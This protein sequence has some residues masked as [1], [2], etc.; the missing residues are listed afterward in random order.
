MAAYISSN[1][2]LHSGFTSVYP[3]EE[4]EYY[5]LSASQKR[6]YLLY[7]MTEN[8]TAYNIPLV[9]KISGKPNRKRL[10]KT[11]RKLIQRHECLRTTFLTANHEPVQ[12]I[13]GRVSFKTVVLNL[14]GNYGPEIDI[15]AVVR[16]FIRPFD[17]SKAPLFR[18][19]LINVNDVDSYHLLVI[20]IHHV[21]ADGLS[22]NVM[23]RDF[24]VLY[25]GGE[26]KRLHTRYVDYAE[27]QNLDKQKQSI[28]QQEKYWLEQYRNDIP[29]LEL[30]LDYPRPRNR[31]FSGGAVHFS[32]EKSVLQ[33]LED[34]S[35]QR[36]TTLFMLLLALYHIFLSK[37]TGQ[38]EIVIG[39]PVSGRRHA[40]LEHLMGVFINTLALRNSSEGKQTFSDFLEQIKSSSL[41]AF[42]NQDYP[43]EEL[44]DTVAV[45]R[46]LSRNPIFDTTFVLN[47]HTPGS[48][49]SDNSQEVR[50]EEGKDELKITPLSYDSGTTKFD[51]SL[52][53]LLSGDSP[54]FTFYYGKSLFQPRTIHR[55]VNYF[56]GAVSAVIAGPDRIIASIDV[57]PEKERR[58]VLYEFNATAREL[59]GLSEIQWLFEA[60]ALATPDRVA[61][62]GIHPDHPS[63]PRNLQLTYRQVNILSGYVAGDLTEKGV[64][65]GAIVAV[66]IDRSI[67]T[68]IRILGILKAG[69]AYLPVDPAYPQE[70]INYMLEDC[71]TSYVL[72]SKSEIPLTGADF[73]SERGMTTVEDADGSELAYIIYTS[74]STGKPRGVMVEHHSVVNLVEGQKLYFGIRTRRHYPAV[75]HPQFRCIRGTGVYRSNRWCCIGMHSKGNIAGYSRIQ[76]LPCQSMYYPSSRSA[77]FP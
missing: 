53:C 70:R 42:E 5:R 71:R 13:R 57:L 49:Q 12:R 73:K 33:E 30:P 50:G 44:V 21:I 74:G 19:G 68:I 41:D 51:L 67:E 35:S 69:A 58:E 64:R 52:T 39:T 48:G 1:R 24:R 7:R 8:N 60:Q 34:L 10:N 14:P 26:P 40:D 36:G 25:N 45:E 22:L 2:S 46:D 77:F 23:E 54:G 76:P 17:L 20:D 4:K 43:F 59:P 72:D 37:I 47:I 3:A 6:L 62:T 38:Q 32:M 31:D 66:M 56:K 55:F 18:A 11:F 28:I 63:F 15:A 61:L 27:W 29:V 75:F 65:S 9:L 16:A